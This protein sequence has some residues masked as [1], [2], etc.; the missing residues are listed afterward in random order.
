MSWSSHGAHLSIVVGLVLMPG[1]DT[2][3]MLRASPVAGARAGCRRR[4]GWSASACPE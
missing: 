3:V 4:P 2:V 1:P